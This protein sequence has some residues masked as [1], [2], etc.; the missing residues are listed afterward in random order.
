M[1]YLAQTH[2]PFKAFCHM[3]KDVPI[4]L[5]LAFGFAID[6][7]WLLDRR[8]WLV[9]ALQCALETCDV[10][11]LTESL[12]AGSPVSGPCGTGA[13]ELVRIG[14]T[15]TIQ[16]HDSSIAVVLIKSCAKN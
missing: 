16:A 12:A 3:L 6:C 10:P 14:D 9:S 2:P 5:V 4:P 15:S 1:D 13:R 11:P 8:V 7:S